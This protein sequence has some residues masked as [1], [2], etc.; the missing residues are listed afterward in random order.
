MLSQK[1][2]EIVKSTVP[3]LKT[4]GTDI[5]T[6]FYKT[7]FAAHPELLNIF[8]QTNQS[9]G[10]QQTALANAVLAAASYID[11]LETILPVVEQIAHKHRSLGIQPEQYPIVGEFLLKAIKAVL[12]D[13]ATEE[14]LQAWAEAYGAIA[15]V[16]IEVEKKMYREAE[17][18]R[19]GWEGFKPFTVVKKVK[20]SNAITSFY[21]KPADG[22]PVPSYLP[23]Q[24][25]TL[26]VKIP[27]ETYLF[28]RQYSLSCGPGHEYFRI[29][30]K[31]EAD[32]EPNG[33]V[34]TYLHDH[35]KTGDEL[36][37]SAPAGVFTLTDEPAPVA[38]ISGGVGLTPLMSMLEALA[39]AG[40][41]REI[42]FIHAARN[43]DF[44]AF[45]AE[46]KHHIEKLENG[47]YYFGYGHPLYENSGCDFTGHLSKAFLGKIVTTQT[48]CYICGP[49]PFL[50]NAVQILTEL[51][52]AKENIR[53][54]FFGPAMELAPAAAV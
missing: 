32:H 45:K 33:K 30:V 8:N 20:E 28:N 41:K 11:H 46:A 43:E 49:V 31:R 51:G 35:V 15:D 36:E 21:L 13:A 4:Q 16:F 37:I 26:R 7:M 40:S 1:T 24:Y 29:S 52:V 23:G 9:Q 19:G 14:V 18:K 10:R 48:V 50:R 44:H 42:H 5:T 53:Y 47:H 27:G 17:T 54:E 39:D 12:G 2:I 3:V 22:G 38:L 6:Y 25:L 34:S